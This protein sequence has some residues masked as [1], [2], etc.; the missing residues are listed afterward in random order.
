M[1]EMINTIFHSTELSINEM[2]NTIF[3]STDLS[4]NEL[5]NTKDVGNKRMTPSWQ[6]RHGWIT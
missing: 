6:C 1:N 3:H 5:I 4:I 2:I